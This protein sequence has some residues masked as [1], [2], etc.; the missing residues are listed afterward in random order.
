MNEQ[1]N[2][3][4]VGILSSLL[5]GFRQGYNTQYALFRVIEIW[6]K[7]LDVS[8]TIG[9]ILIDLSKAYDCIPHD[10][11]IAK[12]DAYGLNRKAL[13]LAYS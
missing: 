10:L 3:H 7:H 1:I 11:L 13:K 12:I 8:G 2:Q 5:S 6:K 4:F 9:T